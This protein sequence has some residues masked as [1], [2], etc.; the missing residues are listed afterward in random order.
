[1]KSP[2]L[3]PEMIEPRDAKITTALAKK[4]FRAYVTQTKALYPEEISEHVS[5]LSEE[6]RQHEEML[7]EEVRSARESF[8]EEVAELRRELAAL[9]RKLQRVS[10]PAEE[11]EMASEIEEAEEELRSTNKYIVMTYAK[12]TFKVSYAFDAS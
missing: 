2:E 3:K 4:I 11:G 7:R 9:K 1:M 10:S 12:E 6:I 8:G 5:Y